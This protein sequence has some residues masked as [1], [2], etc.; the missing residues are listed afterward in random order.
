M[1]FALAGVLPASV[2]LMQAATGLIDFATAPASPGVWAYRPLP[3]GSEALFNNLSGGLQLSVRCT[4]GTR[5]VTISRIS[6]APASTLFVWT[7]SAQRSLTARF[8]PNAMRIS[9]D[10]AA[11][12]AL[13]DAIAF[14]RG[15][16]A[17][18]IPGAKP[19][20][21]A[22]GPEAARVFEDCRT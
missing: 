19:L 15:R 22:P 18:S 10:V 4:R 13:L 17:V 6:S 2:L 12:D 11:N 21:V 1:I 3:G 7:S 16:I 14:S 9:A 5:M 8:E 20:L